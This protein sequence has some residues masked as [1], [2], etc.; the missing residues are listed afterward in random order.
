LAINTEHHQVPYASIAAPEVKAMNE[1]QKTLQQLSL[2]QHALALAFLLCYGSAIGS[3]FGPTGRLRAAGLALV[4]G[5]LFI[6]M[7][8]PWTHGALLMLFAVG[9]VGAFIAAAWSFSAFSDS[10]G[11]RALR[12]LLG[13][14]INEKDRTARDA[15]PPSVDAPPMPVPRDRRV[16]PV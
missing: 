6:A 5:T 1:L 10:F 7:T 9:S 8:R 13:G 16:R 11:G 15:V 14:A 4:A 3:M 2:E 12:Q